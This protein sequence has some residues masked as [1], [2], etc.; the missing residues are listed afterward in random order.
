MKAASAEKYNRAPEPKHEMSDKMIAPARAAGQ[1]TR[2][3][4][5]SL[6]TNVHPSQQQTPL[7]IPAPSAPRP[8]ARPASLP[9]SL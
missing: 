3:C 6:V 2:H 7:H 4:S 1:L 9:L 8:P 5:R